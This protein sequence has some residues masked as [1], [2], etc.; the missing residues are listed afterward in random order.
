VTV[1]KGTEQLDEKGKQLFQ[2]GEQIA[3]VLPEWANEILDW[4]GVEAQAN[5]IGAH[6]IGE[7]IEKIRKYKA[8]PTKLTSRS[9]EL[10]RSYGPKGG[11]YGTTGSKHAIQYVKV[12]GN[13]VVGTKGSDLVYAA[14]HEFGGTINHPGGTPYIVTDEGAVFMRKDGNYPKGVQFTQPHMIRIPARPTLKKAF[15]ETAPKGTQVIHKRIEEMISG[16]F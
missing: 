3:Q 5:M 2:L 6:G 16:R 1:I 10:I 9:G 13:Q 8:H 4:I 7:P 15:D 12:Q 11:A 14:I